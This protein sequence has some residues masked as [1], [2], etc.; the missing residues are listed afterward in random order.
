MIHRLVESAF[1]TRC[2]SVESEGLIRQMVALRSYSKKDLEALQRLQEAI[3]VGQIKR[4]A[5][6]KMVN[7]L[8]TQ[9]QW[10]LQKAER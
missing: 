9:H 2:L 1:Q 10:N 6:G 4:E 7:L 5:R 3:L 8:P